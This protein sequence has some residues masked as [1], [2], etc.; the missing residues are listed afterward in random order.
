MKLS[1]QFTASVI[2]ILAIALITTYNSQV[3]VWKNRNRQNQAENDENRLVL[4]T[5]QQS[6]NAT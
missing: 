6:A 5:E 4:G 3:S 2:S 1:V